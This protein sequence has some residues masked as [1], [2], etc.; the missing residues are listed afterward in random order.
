MATAAAATAKKIITAGQRRS[1][2][3]LLFVVSDV[4]ALEIALFFGYL[5]RQ[6]LKPIFP[7]DLQPMQYNGLALGVLAIPLAYLLVG[8]Y[9][10]YGL[11]PVERLRSRF[12]ATAVVFAFLVSWDYLVQRSQWSRGILIATSIFAFILPTLFDEILRYFLGKNGWGSQSAIIL[13]AGH[14]GKL[15]VKHLL[16]YPSL[17]LSPVA[18]LDDDPAKWGARI[19]GIPVLGSLSQANDLRGLAS[20]A[21]LAIPGLSRERTTNVLQDINFPRVVIIPNLFGIPSLW[22]TTRDFGGILGLEAHRHFL[23][24]SNHAFKRYLDLILGVPL[25]VLSLPIMAICAIWIK[26]KSPSAPALFRHTREGKDG[27]PLEVLKLRTMF[28]DAE[29][30]LTSYLANHPE[31]KECW[32]RYFKLK[33]DPRIIPGIGQLLRRFSLDELPQLWHVVTGD[34]SLVGP[35]PFPGYHLAEFPADFR[36]LRQ[37][38]TPGLTGL[39]QVSARSDGDLDVQ[40]SLD[41][42]YIRNWSPWLD[43][44]ILVH[45][46]RIVVV[47]PGAY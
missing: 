26:L 21:I 24:P 25:F 34:M 40:Q 28:P 9:P 27:R 30:M 37:T 13:G 2:G 20:M 10:G 36:S 38:I 8:L 15:I 46:V 4:I 29:N 12:R 44:H 35:R 17:G 33:K 6:A 32:E 41:T 16:N 14:T 5:I 42:Y 45:T 3:P 7:L 39:W 47:G 1:W 22:I 31:E 23:R 18:I 19:A 43:L 11:N